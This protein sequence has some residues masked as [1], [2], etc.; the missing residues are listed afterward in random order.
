M[1][2]RLGVQERR[3]QLVRSS[4]TAGEGSLAIA[5]ALPAAWGLVLAAIGA[6]LL[7]VGAD[8]TDAGARAAG[9]RCCASVPPASSSSRCC[10]SCRCV[11]IL[12]ALFRRYVAAPRK[13]AEDARIMLAANPA[14]RAAPRRL[15]GNPAPRREQSTVSPTRMNRCSDDVGRR[16]QEANARIEQERNR[17]AALMSELAQSVVVCNAEGR[18]LLYNARAR[19]LLRKRGRRRVR[20]RARRR[21]SSGWGARSSRSSTATSSSTRSRAFTTAC[22]RDTRGPV[23]SFVTT[24]P[25]RAAGPRAGGARP[26]A[27]APR[28]SGR[29]RN[30]RFRARAGRH[31]AP[32]RERQSPRPAAADADAGNARVARQRARRGRDDRRVSRDGQGRPGTLHRRHRRRSAAAFGEARRD[33]RRVRRLAAHRV[34]ARGHARRRPRR[35]GAAPDRGEARAADQAGGRSTSRSGSTS[36]ATR[37][38]NRS[39]TSRPAQGRVWHP[40]V[41]LRARPRRARSRTSTSSGPAR[42]SEPRRRWRGRPTRWSWAARRAR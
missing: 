27:P 14:H 25:V 10:C 8:L 21:A 24:A 40:R 35:G 34:A 13:L 36:T 6:T 18:I 30:H 22:G 26:G 37:C 28:R 41:P 4:E 33:G 17:L 12:N 23:A 16:V 19:Q 11:F 7:L 1:S 3:G 2:E 42:R 39:P 5:L 20:R 29:R 31:H 9:F 32:Y 15:A 38:C